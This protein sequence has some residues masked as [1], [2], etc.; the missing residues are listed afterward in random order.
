MFKEPL[1]YALKKKNFSKIYEDPARHE[2]ENFEL[3]HCREED[4]IVIS[5][6][7]LNL[8]G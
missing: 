6:F 5:K 8:E 2:G 7:R 4:L 1:G 3:S